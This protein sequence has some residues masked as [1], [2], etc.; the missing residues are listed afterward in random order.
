MNIIVCVKQV[1]D[2]EIPPARFRIDTATNKVVPPP[3]VPPVI[4]VFD[5]RAVE[6]ACRLKEK[7]GG[8]ITAITMGTGKVVDVVK[9][10]MSMGADEGIV[11]QDRAFEDLDSFGTA[12]VL[13]KAIQKVGPFDL[14]LCGRQAAD[15]DQGQVGA[16]M[17]ET[18]GIPVVSVARDIQPAGGMLRVQRVL[19]NG[20]EVV[21]APVPCLVTVS[22]EI[23]LPRLPTGMGIIMAARKKVPV[24]TAQDIGTDAGQIA[25]AGGHTEIVSLFVPVR[26]ARCEIIVGEDARDTGTK[27]ALKLR[28]LRLI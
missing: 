2:P 8:K 24:W 22:N 4:S 25:A 23:G 3:G 7:H 18:L 17:A 9:H 1:P 15:W 11:L 13:A 5:E 20:Y 28:E 27:L 6:A 19:A 16:I 12:F 10:A 26:E 14:I 21:E